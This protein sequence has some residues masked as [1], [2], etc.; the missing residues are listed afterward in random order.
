MHSLV[1]GSLLG[2]GKATNGFPLI[3]NVLQTL[4]LIRSDCHLFTYLFTFYKY[5][6]AYSLM[7][8]T[9]LQST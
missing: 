7:Y 5:N 8:V 1:P 2:S 6:C 3:P 4:N 9:E